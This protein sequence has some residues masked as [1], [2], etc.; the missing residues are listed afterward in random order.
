[1]A[2]ERE[3]VRARVIANGTGHGDLGELHDIPKSASESRERPGL[4]DGSS[5]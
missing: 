2:R 1:M 4:T 5:Q 3:E